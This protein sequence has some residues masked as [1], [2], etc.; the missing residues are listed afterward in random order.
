MEQRDDKAECERDGHTV[1]HDPGRLREVELDRGVQSRRDAD[2]GAGRA[3]ALRDRMGDR[4]RLSTGDTGADQR[5]GEAGDVL[6]EQDL[7][8]YCEA[9]DGAVVTQGL[10]DAGD[11]SV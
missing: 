2:R 8:E 9:E 6:V 11:L 4:A 3:A 7:A 10:G 1:E 5:L